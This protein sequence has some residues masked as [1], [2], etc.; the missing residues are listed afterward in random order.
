MAFLNSR[1]EKLRIAYQYRRLIRSKRIDMALN[2]AKGL[3]GPDTAY[4]LYSRRDG[5][6]KKKS[7]PADDY[8]KIS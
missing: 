7:I 3:V 1:A 2:D 8:E 5:G 6:R 4:H